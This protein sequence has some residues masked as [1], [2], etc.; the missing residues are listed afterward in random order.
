MIKNCPFCGGTDLSIQQGT[1]DREG[2]PHN[3]FCEDCGAAGPWEYIPD[4]Q[5]TDVEECA[6]RTGWNERSQND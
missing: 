1:P 3:I 6:E 2:I 5:L 4:G